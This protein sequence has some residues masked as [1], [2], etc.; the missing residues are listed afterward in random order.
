MRQETTLIYSEALVRR[1]IFKFWRRTL[2]WRYPAALML[3]A[4]GLVGMLLKGDRSWLVG[5]VGAGFLL[6]VVMC[7]LLYVS[8]YRN[9]LGRF[10]ALEGAEATLSLDSETFTLTSS[11]GSSTMPWKAVTE[12]WKFQEIWL[13]LF[14]K[15]QFVTLPLA[16]LT[17]EMRSAIS[18]RV[19]HAGGRVDA[20]QSSKP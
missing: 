8:H 1:A 14:S 5:L 16:S 18:D 15:A 6:G 9:S 10:R 12:V 17:P 3:C 19:A 11:E 7:A 20:Y 13:L 4:V 2:G